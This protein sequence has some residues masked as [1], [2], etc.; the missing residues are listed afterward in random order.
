MSY[1]Y[2]AG[3]V[4][5]ISPADVASVCP[6]EYG[7]LNKFMTDNNLTLND[8][9]PDGPGYNLKVDDKDFMKQLDV[10]YNDLCKAFEEKTGLGLEVTYISGDIF[11][12][13]IPD[14]E[15]GGACFELC[16]A[17]DWTPE[18]KKLREICPSIDRKYF[19]QGG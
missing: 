4:D 9:A 1:N 10:F 14:G 18:A 12:S 5:Y 2:Y 7:L 6:Y 3:C 17:K 16:G 11:N 13:Q 8:I 15:E 19:V